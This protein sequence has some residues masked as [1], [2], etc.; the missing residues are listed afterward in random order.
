M[1]TSEFP[2][3]HRA[4]PVLSLCKRKKAITTIPPLIKTGAAPMHCRFPRVIEELS[5]RNCFIQITIQKIARLILIS[6]LINF[7]NFIII[8]LY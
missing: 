1:S 6:Y 5:W 7:N 8:Y 3:R 2:I 4:V